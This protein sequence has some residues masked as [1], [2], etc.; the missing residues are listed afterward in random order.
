M[1]MNS[2]DIPQQNIIWMALSAAM[3]F[4][5]PVAVVAAWKLLHRKNV[6]WMPLLIGAV[7]FVV[8]ARVLESIPH[9]FC[10][11]LDNP[12]SGFIREHTWAYVLYGVTMAGVF[13]E[14]GRYFIMGKLMKRNRTRENVVMY[15]IGHGGIEVWTVVLPLV[16]TY[17]MV[18]L[19]VDMGS[20]V[21]AEVQYSVATFDGTTG[22]F[23]VYERMVAMLVHVL[24]T[25]LVA[26][27]LY[28]GKKQ[29]LLYAVGAHMMLDVAPALYQRQV[30]SL[31]TCEWVITLLAVVASLCV[32]PLYKRM[33]SKKTSTPKEN[34]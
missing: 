10:I 5:L 13:E 11:V 15:G 32:L 25:I 4:L 30:C 27:S 2:I 21:P 14:V 3:L 8:S 22:A 31:A 23:F 18:A 34:E 19:G 24:F 28:T 26:Y 6:S 20:P 7:G 29:Y 17:L 9:V 33:S 12:V 1:T 16:L